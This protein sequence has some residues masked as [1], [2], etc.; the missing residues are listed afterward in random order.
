MNQLLAKIT[1]YELL[2]PLPIGPG[3][4]NLDKVTLAT[5]I[6]GIVNLVIGIAGVLAVV[7]IIYGGIQ[8]MST[9]AFQGKNDAKGTINH[10][11]WGLVLTIGAWL[12]LYTVN[13]KL[14]DFNLDIQQQDLGAALTPPN[15][16]T[17]EELRTDSSIR[18]DLG[19]ARNDNRVAITPY[20]GPCYGTVT[21]GCVNVDKLQRSVVDGL[22]TLANYCKECGT[23]II[24][25]GSEGGHTTNSLH[26]RGLAVDISQNA[27]LN[28]VITANGGLTKEGR[29]VGNLSLVECAT[30]TNTNFP[31]RFLWE[32][33]GA[34]CGG[35]VK[36]SND[37]WHISY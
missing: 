2:T 12:I 27:L 14:L 22:K 10:A 6:P 1:E 37:H 4:T 11:I 33:T 5:Y 32:P 16:L 21:T 9:D 17:A 7:M 30:Y 15:I 13:P 19:N 34:T 36:S 31:G 28:A 8:Y 26:D 35:D 25:G 24:T 20:T 23:I 18:S 29:T 3:A